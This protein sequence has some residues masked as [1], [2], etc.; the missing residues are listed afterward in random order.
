MIAAL[1]SPSTSD[2]KI[3]VPSMIATLGEAGS[4]LGVGEGAAVG[5]GVAA[6]FWVGGLDVAPRRGVCAA[7]TINK[8]RAANV[9]RIN[10][11]KFIRGIFLLAARPLRSANLP[12]IWSTIIFEETRFGK[13]RCVSVWLCA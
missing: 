3:A 8:S 4:A 11:G 12:A 2:A 13:T 9:A 1:T 5:A 6:G 10:L 7:M